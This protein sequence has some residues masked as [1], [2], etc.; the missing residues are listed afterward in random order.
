MPPLKTG[1]NSIRSNVSQLMKPPM[2]PSRK[3]AISTIARTNNISRSDAQMKQSLAIA[4][5]YARK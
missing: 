5:T 3:K 2:S 1:I 4:K